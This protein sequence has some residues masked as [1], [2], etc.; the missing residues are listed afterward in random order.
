M[1]GRAAAV[2][3]QKRPG[4]PAATADRSSAKQKTDPRLPACICGCNTVAGENGIVRTRLE[5]MQVPADTK[6]E[7][8]ADDTARGLF[9]PVR[10]QKCDIY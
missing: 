3:G 6:K 5:Y 1:A 10:Q 2:A 4:S 7:L 8:T 9:S